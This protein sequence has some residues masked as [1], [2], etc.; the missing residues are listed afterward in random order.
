M[1]VLVTGGTGFIG[2]HLVESLLQNGMEVF[3]L[4]RAHSNLRWLEP[5]S[6]RYIYGELLDGASLDEA[7][8]DKD[9]IFHL[10]G[11]TKAPDK[12][13]YDRANYI[14]TKNLIEAVYRTNRGL[15]RF[16]YVSSL[17]AVG[18]SPDSQPRTESSVCCPVTDYGMS[19]LKGEN[20]V[21]KYL[22]ILPITIVRPPVVYGPRDRDLFLYFKAVNCGVKPVL[23]I[24]KYI[25]LI[26]VEDL[27][28]GIIRAAMSEHSIGRTYFIANDEP[29]AL[30]YL[31]ELVRQAVRLKA[32]TFYLPDKLIY[33]A[34]GLS[35]YLATLQGKTTIF[36][37][38]KAHELAQRAWVCSAKQAR[39]ELGFQPMVTLREGF[40]RTANWYRAQGWL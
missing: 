3:C 26:Y 38:Q 28:R 32:V 7:V 1:K 19:K 20:E 31:T 2:S 5:L 24:K 18:P 12:A 27:V 10:A 15:K 37:R 4:V 13:G 40:S 23:G 25:S 9:I 8:R 6:V 14:G 21:R 35:E 30:E 29:T 36:N 34:A 33:L 39:A 11:L 22:T 17:A 16:L